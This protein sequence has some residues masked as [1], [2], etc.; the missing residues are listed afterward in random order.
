MIYLIIGDSMSNQTLVITTII[1]VVI[2][3][4]VC[5]ICFIRSRKTKKIKKILSE[6]EIEKNKINSS[7]V[8]P[9]LAKVEAYL[10]NEKVKNV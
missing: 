4:I 7:P 9:E 5:V 8:I 10:G 6:L 1:I 2:I 3:S